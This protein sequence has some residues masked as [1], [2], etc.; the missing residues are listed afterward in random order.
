MKSIVFI[1][2]CCLVFFGGC[3]QKRSGYV[4]NYFNK[5]GY[6]NNEV[7]PET[8]NNSPKMHKATMRPYQING[9]WY[10]PSL[11][12]VGSTFTG[13]A[14]WYG[15]N[16][17]LKKTS[18]GEVYNM[19]AMTAAH[20]TF[21]MNTMVKVDNLDNGKSTIV[22]VND[23]GPF[24]EGRIIDLSNAAAHDIAM[25]GKG[26]ANV[27]LTILGFNAKIATTQEELEAT[28]SAAKFLIQVGAFRR[29]AGANE[30]KNKLANVFGKSYPMIVREGDFEGE[31]I[32]R[33]FVSGFRSIAEAEDFKVQYALG[34]VMIMAE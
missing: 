23:R 29:V 7:V 20:K 25:V 1:S 26:I 22:R 5:S 32:Y 6:V 15:P 9:I 13:L 4:T 28:A 19:H 2:F 14:S 8:I 33:V 34:R 11:E 12:H 16:F 31:P 27:K 24:V 17:H 10:E 18:N 30:T 3:V 21:P